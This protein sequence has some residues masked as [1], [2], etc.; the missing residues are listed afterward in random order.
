MVTKTRVKFNEN[1]L[2]QDSV[3]FNHKKVVSI[4]IVYEISKSININDNLTLEKFLF[5]AVRLT[6]N[7]DIDKYKYSGYGIGFDRKGFF[8][9]G[10]EV[11]KNVIIFRVDMSSSSHNDNEKKDIL[12]LGKGPTQGLEQSLTAENCIQLILPKK[13]QNFV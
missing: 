2:K 3:T 4:Y 7:A 12:I 10:N 11:G 13:T 5:G 1:S 8:S 6:K 9:I